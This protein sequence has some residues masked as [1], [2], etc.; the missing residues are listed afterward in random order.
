MVVL[1]R[2]F[3]GGLDC[4]GLRCCFQGGLYVVF[5]G[6]NLFLC[7]AGIA[8]TLDLSFVFWVGWFGFLLWIALA[9]LFA[10][11]V[12]IAVTGDLDVVL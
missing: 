8:T 4:G 6:L 9:G 2:C 1:R 7:C 11:S 3:V 12:G 10:D 5:V